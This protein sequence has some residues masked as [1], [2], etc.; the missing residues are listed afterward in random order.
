M[1]VRGDGKDTGSM[2]G[3][4]IAGVEGYGECV[5]SAMGSSASENVEVEEVGV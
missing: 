4:P 1:G 2:V 3:D 5:D